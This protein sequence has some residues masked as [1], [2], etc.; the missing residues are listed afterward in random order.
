[1][2]SEDDL[3]PLSALSHLLYCERRCALVHIEQQWEENVFTVEGRGMHKRSDQSQTESR[4]D[5]RLAHGVW[6]RCL[7][8]GLTGRADLIEFHRVESDEGGVCLP[9]V[10][11]RWRP[12]PVEDKHGR[13]KKDFT[14]KVQL[15]GQA[16]CLEEMMGVRIS[17]GA[18]YYGK[19]RHRLDVIFDDDL[20]RRTEEAAHRLRQLFAGGV[21][22]SAVY[23]PKCDSCSLYEQCQPKIIK[24]N[25]VTAWLRRA[26]SE[27]VA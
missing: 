12:F 19:T 20:R 9:G 5:I 26:I 23:E 3:L 16:L 15:C 2:F 17:S 13:P 27:A 21:T 7:R 24:Q 11:G 22:P 14:D 4:G 25:D 1:M 18:L 8:L 6:L 10:S